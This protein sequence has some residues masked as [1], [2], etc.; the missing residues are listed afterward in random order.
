MPGLD[1]EL[2]QQQKNLIWTQHTADTSP[3][4]TN[5]LAKMA[6]NS[7]VYNWKGVATLLDIL[8]DH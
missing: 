1:N 4:N 8:V 6:S 3:I 5:Q 7:L 2:C